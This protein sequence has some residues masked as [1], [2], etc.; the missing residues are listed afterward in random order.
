MRPKLQPIELPQD[1]PQRTETASSGV[2]ID[3]TER[4]RA[5]AAHR[6]SEEKFKRI[7]HASLD[8][9]VLS[10]VKES[11][12]LDVNGEFVNLTGF[13]AEEVIGRTPMELGIWI[14]NAG[15]LEARRREIEARRIVRNVETA[16]RRKDGTER[17]ALFSA[18]IVEIGGQPRLLSFIRDITERRQVERSLR[19]LSGRLLQLQDQERRRIALELHDS[20][21]QTLAA[22]AMNLALVSESLEK[23]SGPERRALDAAIALAD[24]CSQE[25]RTLSYLLHPPL[26]EEVGLASALRH[27]VDG[28]AE[29]S[30]IDVSC[31]LPDGLERLPR[32]IETT[33]FRVMQES[34]TNIHRHS[35]SPTATVVL[36]KSAKRVTLEVRDRGR[37]IP[38]ALLE[39]KSDAKALGVGIPG[40]RERVRQLGGRL[41]VSSRGRGVTV[42]V[43]LPLPAAQA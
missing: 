3:A 5:A 42:K 21:A 7:F 22:L 37:G 18:V 38:A 11:R 15:D 43:V 9:V 32:E 40:M 34:L 17:W 14:D 35:G 27:F 33:L 8:A 30:G 10:D 31:A 6:E 20:T 29:R 4:E 36:R 1:P 24:Q 16:F 26:L 39:G 23:S 12:Y 25:I 19:E 2:S 41:D 28:F 13:S